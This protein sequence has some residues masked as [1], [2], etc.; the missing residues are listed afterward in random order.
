M[1]AGATRFFRASF[2]GA[3]MFDEALFSG[4]AWFDDASLAEPATFDGAKVRRLDNSK[5]RWAWPSNW[6]VAPDPADPSVGQLVLVQTEA[7]ETGSD[8]TDGNSTPAVEHSS[9]QARD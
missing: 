6:T 8:G 1:F 3:A 2:V 4:N 5:I 9:P 7:G